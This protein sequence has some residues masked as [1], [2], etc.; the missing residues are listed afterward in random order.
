MSSTSLL[1]SLSAAICVVAAAV[2]D[3]NSIVVCLGVK[4]SGFGLQGAA[5]IRLLG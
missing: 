1:P 5:R 3:G 4:F 2:G